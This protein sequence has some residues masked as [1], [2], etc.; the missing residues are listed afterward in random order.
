MEEEPFRS[1]G[2]LEADGSCQKKGDEDEEEEEAVLVQK[3]MKVPGLCHWLQQQQAK[4]T[5]SLEWRGGAG[6]L[7][8]C[9]SWWVG[10]RCRSLGGAE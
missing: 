3:K 9:L 8:E 4:D 1:L 7:Q 5:A 10:G 6:E 2:D